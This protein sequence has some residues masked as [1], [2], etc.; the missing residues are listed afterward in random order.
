MVVDISWW[1]VVVVGGSG[2]G[3]SEIVVSV[4]GFSG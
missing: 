4:G 2:C 3:L 1:F